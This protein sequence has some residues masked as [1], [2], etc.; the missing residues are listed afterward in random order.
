MKQ[1]AFLTLIIFSTLLFKA[2]TNLP[3]ASV[4]LT[5]QGKIF[6][7][8]GSLNGAIITVTQGGRTVSNITT[9]S[10]GKYNFQLP[11]GGDYLVTI[12]KPGLITKKFSITTR[13][14]P[15]ERTQEAFGA[16]DAQVSLWKKVDGVD[17][18]ALDQPA[19]KYAYS[20]DKQNFDYDKAYLDQMLGVI[21]G[22]RQQEKALEKKN[23]DADKNYQAAIKEGDKGFGKK[24]YQAALGKYNEALSLKKD[25]EIA[26][27]KIDQTNQAIKADA[28][29]AAKAKAEADAKV[30]A[31]AAAKKKLADETAAKAVA[32]AKAKA[33]ADAKAKAEADAAAKAKAEADAKVAADAAAKK[34][35]A[36]E[37]SAKAKANADA[38][39]K[40]KAEAD[41][42]VAADAAAK[43]KLAEED[44]AKAKAN[45]DAAAKAKADGDAKAMAELAAKKKLAEEDAAKAKANADAAAKAKADAEVI[46][47]GNEEKGKAKNTVR[48]V[49][50]G[51]DVQYRAAI[52]RGDNNMKFKRYEEAVTA[53]TEA[54][55][56]KAND[57]YATTKLAN[58]KKNITLQPLIVKKEPN[59][60]SLKYPQGKTQLP[61][62]FDKTGTQTTII[63]VKGEDAWVYTKKVFSFGTVVWKKDEN[64]ITQNQWENETK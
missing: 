58:A 17:Y 19:N 14:I 39:A 55:T 22:I 50:G 44:A 53:Y 49:L 47:K 5:V 35:L 37:T 12:S 4:L 54:L 31:D 9:G 33:E 21:D 11:L 64:N 43:K 27:Q 25:D 18:S 48:Q 36:D 28:E 45:A 63:L 32:D 34:K 15:A 62:L 60:L 52:V 42:K 7:D 26:K 59:P 40:A 30:A 61:E 24:D 2:Q 16:I 29:A 41:A 57:A 1:L 20:G 6:E 46:A 8:D 3:P 10:D 38:A 51:N 13:G 56:Y 23:K